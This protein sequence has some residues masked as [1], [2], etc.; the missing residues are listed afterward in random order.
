MAILQSTNITGSANITGSL[1]IDGSLTIGGGNESKDIAKLY[2]VGDG[3]R[4]GYIQGYADGNGSRGLIIGP[5]ATE[6]SSAGVRIADNLI[7]NGNL[8]YNLGSDG[9]IWVNTYTQRVRSRNNSA[10]G[11]LFLQAGHPSC[12]LY[13]QDGNQSTALEVD[14]TKIYSRRDVEITGSNNLLGNYA[15][16]VANSSGT[17]ILAVE[18]DGKVGIGTDNPGRTL[19]VNGDLSVGNRGFW[20][21]D[22]TTQLHL[23]Y[24]TSS[25]VRITTQRGTI[26]LVGNTN[27]D[28]SS[29]TN[30]FTLTSMRG[31]GAIFEAAGTD[32]MSDNL[33]LYYQVSDPDLNYIGAIRRQASGWFATNDHRMIGIGDSDYSND[34]AGTVLW[35]TNNQTYHKGLLLSK[36]GNVGINT[37]SP[38]E[39]LH[40][41][42]NLKLD[43]IVTGSLT[44]A[45]SGSTV[46]DVQGS[47]GQLFSVNDS[48]S[49]SLFKVATISGMPV[50]E[51][52]SDN[53]VKIGTFNN[54][55]IVVSGSHTTL[56][57]TVVTGSFFGSVTDI[58]P[59]NQTASLDCSTGN[60]F[61]L[62]LS[63]SVDTLLTA[64]NIQ[65][66][67]SINLRI[68]Q[69]STSGSLSY[70]SEFK[71][72]NG[73]PYS[74]SA[75]SS[76]EDILSFIA[77]DSTALY[78]SSLKNFQ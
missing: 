11:D 76:V 28:G 33:T 25:S 27:S 54:E 8:I 59:S 18:N 19:S 50:V 46:L 21:S 26:R 23:G 5:H 31:S 64:S 73:L 70:G 32:L 47:L 2:I 43:G 67:Q 9:F 44:I 56:K 66:G 41:S 65:P 53:T 75:T 71:F 51:A 37:T 78:G 45:S 13:L 6:G 62:T 20:Q 63:S 3:G 49:G 35:Y 1:D 74:V 22:G 24:G 55:A 48:F 61:T 69:P 38:T 68:T 42:G 10:Q 57:D 7:P 39:R 30:F 60:F 34:S 58:T 17:D 12:S 77:F 16:K 40:V 52:F 4:G 72:P 15:L 36:T 29:G 14:D